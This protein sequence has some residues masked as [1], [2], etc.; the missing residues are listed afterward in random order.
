MY[1]FSQYIW[2]PNTGD[3]AQAKQY[4]PDGSYTYKTSSGADVTAHVNG[5]ISADLQAVNA[6][7]IKNIMDV[8][9]HN[10]QTIFGSTSHYIRFY[11]GGE[12]RFVYDH[13]GKLIEFS[14]RRVAANLGLDNV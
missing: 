12:I 7:S 14:G 2:K 1:Q 13:T 3:Q 6:V 10:I 11:G 8:E 5:D 4:H 9:M